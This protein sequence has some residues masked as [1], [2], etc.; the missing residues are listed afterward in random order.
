MPWARGA[1]EA[2]RDSF[3][4]Q[5]ALWLGLY[6][7]IWYL[8]WFCTLPPEAYFS[9]SPLLFLPEQTAPF[10]FVVVSLAFLGIFHR[11]VS[12]RAV[13]SGRR[14]RL[15]F[16]PVAAIMVWTFATLHVNHFYGQTYAFDRLVLVVLLV[17]FWIHPLFLAPLLVVMLVL[18]SQVH[19][20]LPEAMWSWADKGLPVEVLIA[21]CCFLFV[22]VVA[23]PRPW[24]PA[25]LT[26]SVAGATYAHAAFSKMRLGD[27][28]FTW[29]LENPL[30][31]LIVSSYA[32]SLWL[33]PLGEEG[34]LT[35]AR[36]LAP[37]GVVM[38]GSVLLLELAGL[39]L[40]VS[41]RWTKILLLG[42]VGMH[43]AI[44]ATSGI[45]FWKWILLDL[46]LIVYVERL[47]KDEAADEAAA[48]EPKADGD[49]QEGRETTE[50]EDGFGLYRPSRTVGSVLTVLAISIFFH[51]VDF[52][53][54]DSKFVNYFTIYGVDEDGRRHRLEARH[55][56]PYDILFQQSRWFGVTREPI[57]VDTYG[58]VQSL[59]LL[60][61]LESID[62]DD[63]PQLVREEGVV[64]YSPQ[65]AE[66]FA[67]FLKRWVEDAESW[68]G[69]TFWPHRLAPP[70]H[71]QRGRPDDVY[72]GE[73]R[74]ESVEV[75]LE[76]AYFDGERL[77]QA[78]PVP[79]M[80]VPVTGSEDGVP[81]EGAE[82]G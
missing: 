34:V 27:S 39:A 75:Y 81:R 40:V 33:K 14:A 70:F 77:L 73:A 78:R 55:F 43:L 72:E 13:D 82:G 21:F 17:L 80:K 8:R 48:A 35:L 46:L 1:V 54:L 66:I 50:T 68:R 37:F 63:V 36:A 28:V 12:W 16:V 41:R 44:L 20:P 74:L 5:L 51:T 6:Y 45:F 22:K 53:W 18:G 29:L 10:L 15:F 9:P 4:V 58:T 7:W 69:K 11:K 26:L 3:W 42:L 61:Q 52:S 23:R 67:R 25:F 38:A 59:E 79:V 31:N 60:R 19:H 76:R 2:W 24:F 71:F 62:P 30:P 57:L 32:Q 49:R 65:Q 56:A 64:H 47:A